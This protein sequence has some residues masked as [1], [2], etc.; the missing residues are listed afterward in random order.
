MELILKDDV[1]FVLRRLRNECLKGGPKE[2]LDPG[3]ARSQQLLDTESL[4]QL[5]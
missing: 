3:L 1:Q 2:M 4:L 5:A